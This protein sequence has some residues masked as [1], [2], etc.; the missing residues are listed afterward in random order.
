MSHPSAIGGSPKRQWPVILLIVVLVSAVSLA[1]GLMVV[2][3]IIQRRME[4]PS[5]ALAANTVAP[6]VQAPVAAPSAEVEIK[7]KIKPPPP[8]PPDPLSQPNQM[9]GPDLSQRQDG[10][11]FTGTGDSRR[12][13]TSDAPSISASISDAGS[14][15]SGGSGEHSKGR[16]TETQ[17]GTAPTERH[18]SPAL[19][20]VKPRDFP[21]S[22][23]LGQPRSTD[24]PKPR[25][26]R[27]P[28]EALPVLNGETQS[29]AT[30]G[31]GDGAAT[32]SNATLSHRTYRV[33]VGRFADESAA[34]R[35]RDEL[36]GAGYSP[37]VV[38]TERSGVVLYRVQ[39]GT[40]GR[41]ENAEKTVSKLKSQSYEPYVADDE[42]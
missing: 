3:P 31:Q 16:G 42:P 5:P 23:A 1:L 41:K 6:R 20:P 7:E 27:S 26:R 14:D 17:E 12:K 11:F 30:T 22:P 37:R 9:P 21:G 25:R 18:D 24:L 2:G 29:G 38:R 40:F 39:V 8:P 33:Q 36:V 35:L 32:A 10:Q 15:R 28:L 34:Q 13:R 19:E 4:T